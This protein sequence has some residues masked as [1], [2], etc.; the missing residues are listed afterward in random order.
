MSSSTTQHESS[1]RESGDEFN[2]VA[3]L[4]SVLKR[5]LLFLAVFMVVLLLGIL[6]AVIRTPQ[7][8]YVSVLQIGSAYGS[9]SVSGRLVEDTDGVVTKLQRSVI[10][11]VVANWIL[12]HPDRPAPEI[13]I[14]GKRN[15]GIVLIM[16]KAGEKQSAE[17]AALH[18]SVVG[19]I[20]EEHRSLVMTRYE[21]IL[22]EARKNLV[23]SE[24]QMRQIKVALVQQQQRKEL[25]ERQLK[26]LN[27]EIDSLSTTRRKMLDPDDAE[28]KESAPYLV[29]LDLPAML[30]RRDILEDDLKIN[31]NLIR[32]ELER[33]LSDTESDK[34]AAAKKVD[35]LKSEINS[36]RLTR[37]ETLASAM[38]DRVGLSTKL[39]LAFSFVLA[40][41]AAWFAVMFAEYLERQ[42]RKQKSLS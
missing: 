12:E 24:A 26:R 18:K 38:P 9:N 41:L 25:L 16:T 37:V 15:A 39:V 22:S 33:K 3:V 32:A 6:L 8:S 28:K 31:Q 14:K 21:S 19:K 35:L 5:K 23:G 36:L 42:I 10:P 17:V 2:P 7:I 27:A 34:D 30:E 1:S 11:A 20:I 4:N 29:Q 13:V 40:L